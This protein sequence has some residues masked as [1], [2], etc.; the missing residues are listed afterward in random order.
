MKENPSVYGQFWQFSIFAEHFGSQS[1]LT[2]SL[3]YSYLPANFSLVYFDSSKKIP[4]LLLISNS[5]GVL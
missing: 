4:P 2:S 1:L 3:F 5:S